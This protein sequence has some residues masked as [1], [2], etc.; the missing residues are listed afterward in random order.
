MTSNQPTLHS[1]FCR[2]IFL[3]SAC[4]IL[5]ISCNPIIEEG[6]RKNDLG[7]D[8]EM[9][10]DYGAI[11][12]RLSDETPRHRNNFIKLVNQGFFD[13]LLFHRVI[14][15]FVIQTGD[16]ESKHADRDKKLGAT[17]L[18][19]K[20]PAEFRSS[21]FHKRGAL[22][23]AREGDDMNPERASSST[24]FT[25]VQG[26]TYTDSTLAISAGRI[27]N[28]LAY[29]AV[30][31]QPAHQAEFELLQKIIK[32]EDDAD[33]IEY[34][35]LKT[36]FDTLAKVELK[37]METYVYPEAHREVYKTIGGAAHLDQNYTVF[38][39]VVKGMDIVDKIG[40]V[41]T[42]SL[43]KPVD[44]VRILSV[45]LIPRKKY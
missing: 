17:D 37:N 14:Q 34:K 6:V 10:T 8:I 38:G 26:R 44:E 11:I 42:D 39:E 23:A 12:M 30:I 1:I 43:D 45:K 31:H 35:R 9:L 36:K 2:V 18:P 19:Y 22:N 25:I 3:L 15:N 33:S 20:V 5:T 29:N 28:W 7:K 32:R 24:Q 27:N 16:P 21:L 13:S 41:Q 4:T 40:A